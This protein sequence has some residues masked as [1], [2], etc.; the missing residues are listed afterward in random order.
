MK[1]QKIYINEMIVGG[2]SNP[3]N[4]EKEIKILP[5]TSLVQPMEGQYFISCD[6]GKTHLIKPG[7][8]FIASAGAVQ[9]I[10]HIN[11]ETTGR[12]TAR[13]IFFDAVVDNVFRLEQVF[14]FPVH[15][16][17]EIAPSLLLDMD[18]FF[19]ADSFCRRMSV[20]YR[21]VDTLLSFS[22][23]KDTIIDEKMQLLAA[24]MQKN[25]H[26]ALTIEDLSQYTALSESYLYARFKQAFG[27]SPI[28]LMT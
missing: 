28:H 25:Y 18:C 27:V 6:G 13:W 9:E 17:K 21:M 23:E 12:M 22:E 1:T 4:P 8:M 19:E 7:E 5:Y 2:F 26:L 11:D 20:L 14:S 15:I 16:T 3:V 24:Y 10:S